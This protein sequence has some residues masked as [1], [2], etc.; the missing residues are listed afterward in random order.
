MSVETYEGVLEE[1]KICLKDGAKL[2][3]YAKVFVIVTEEVIPVTIDRKKP[4]Q[5]LSPHFTRREDA[6]RFELIVTE[7]KN[8]A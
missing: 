8:N 4:V 3:N 1:G 6:A 2:S 5:I 7:E